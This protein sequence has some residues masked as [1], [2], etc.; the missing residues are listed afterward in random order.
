MGALG[1]PLPLLLDSQ[2]HR[3]AALGPVR[4][5]EG[6]D[7]K[8]WAQLRCVRN[9]EHTHDTRKITFALP[10]GTTRW[11]T[12]V[13]ITNVMVGAPFQAPDAEKPKQVVKPYNPI[14]VD[15]P[16]SFTILVKKYEGARIGGKLHELQAGQTIGVKGGFQQWT[17]EPFK[18]AH[19]G[20]VAGGT[21][22]TPLIQAASHILEHDSTAKV[23]LLCAN[24]SPRDV[25]LQGD[26]AALQKRFGSRLV[27]HHHIDSV[28]GSPV[29][30]EVLKRFMPAAAPG[31]LIMVCGPG[32]M[33]SAVAG[34][35]AKD[36]TQGEVGGFL[37]DMGYSQVHIWKV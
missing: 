13:P 35:K 34:P 26:L 15:E 29:S 31:V 5:D 3:A 2:R 10:E 4:N 36:F 6:L 23:T 11:T 28:A 21:G 16:G 14:S 25:L 8:A 24:K 27:I 1:V 17:F 33:V 37:K 18:Y 20:M 12:K 7:S 30:E 19:Y 9:E 32:G 22:I